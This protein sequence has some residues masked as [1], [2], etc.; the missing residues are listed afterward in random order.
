MAPF[1]KRGV[2]APGSPAPC[3]VSAGFT[4]LEVLVALVVLAVGVA[5]TMSVIT[6]SLGNIRKSQIRTRLMASAQ[7][8]MESALNNDNLEAPSS[9]GQEMPGG[10]QCMV[11]V[12][13]EPDT[14]LLTQPASELPIRLL[15]Y[16]VQLIGPDLEPV[17]ALETLK[18]VAANE[19]RQ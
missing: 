2:R 8:V 7:T 19:E 5:V 16:T 15:H 11:T 17:Y 9:Y 13:E 18:L 4:L 12:E 1:S 3:G 14:N 10:F 6:G